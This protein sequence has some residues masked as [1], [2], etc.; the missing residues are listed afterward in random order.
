[1]EVNY[2]GPRPAYIWVQRLYYGSSHQCYI[3]NASGGFIA[4]ENI[5]YGDYCD[6]INYP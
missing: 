2:G 4:V 6:L 1:M 5:G 3:T